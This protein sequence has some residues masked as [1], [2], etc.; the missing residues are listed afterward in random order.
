[1]LMPLTLQVP[2][3]RR[4]LPSE[5][6]LPLRCH[7]SPMCLIVHDTLDYTV[8]SR[9]KEKNISEVEVRVLLRNWIIGK[10]GN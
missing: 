6:R 7:R 3:L 9:E 1:M 2:V 5:E 8:E 4:R 10:L